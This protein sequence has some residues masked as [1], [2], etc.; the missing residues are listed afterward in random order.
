MDMIINGNKC[1]SGNGKIIDVYNPAT[2]EL[3]DT[4]PS[5]TEQDANLCLDAAYAGKK[6]W[7]NTPLYKRVAIIQEFSKKL[8]ARAEE[9]GTLLCREM[10]KPISQATGEIGLMASIA[11]GYAERAAHLYDMA[12]PDNCPGYSKDHI[13]TRREP[14]G[15]VLCILPFNFPIYIGAH[16]II[17][18]LLMGNA[19]IL[20][21]PSSNPLTLIK[22]V[23]V[24]HESGVPTSALHVITGSGSMLG[25]LLVDSDKINAVAFTGSTEVGQDI[26]QR[27]AKHLHHVML[28]LGGNDPFIVF[29]DADLDLAVWE[30]MVGR[31]SNAG[32]VC[33]S[34]KRFIVQRSVKDLFVQKLHELL[35]KIPPSDPMNPE[36]F[37]GCLIDEKAAIGCEKQVAHTVEQGATLVYG[38]TRNGAFFTPALLDNV[39]P[40]MDVAKDMEIFGPVFPVIAFDTEEEALAIANASQFGLAGA[41]FSKDL[42]KAMRVSAGVESGTL[43]INGNNSNNRHQDHAFGGYKMSGYGREGISATLEELSQVKTIFLKNVW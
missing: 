5:A 4:V 22:I 28:E 16:K 42:A 38:G 6:E 23:E 18:A 20:K 36:T 19:V 9:L 14:L 37:L 30:A 21:P 34:P 35:A 31:L 10:G 2:G 7:A 43:V 13:F 3:V 33:C 26:A 12:I 8:A 29:E 24:L 40:E 41:V 15:V 11:A 1:Q 39:T 27:A 17:P 32:Q 25:T